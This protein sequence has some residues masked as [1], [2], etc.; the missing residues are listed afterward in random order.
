MRD[1]KYEPPM[2]W[3][4][5]MQDLLALLLVEVHLCKAC[6]EDLPYGH[7]CELVALPEQ[8]EIRQQEESDQNLPRMDRQT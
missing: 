8:R 3:R 5:I 1:W 6:D 2:E 4:S 7:T